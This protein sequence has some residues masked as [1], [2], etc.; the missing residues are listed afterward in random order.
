[1]DFFFLF[2]FFFIE[3]H[4]TA[5][6]RLRRQAGA[7][8]LRVVIFATSPA[9]RAFSIGQ[10]TA[11]FILCGGVRP[12][13]PDRVCVDSMRRALVYVCT[14]YVCTPSSSNA[15]SDNH[16]PPFFPTLLFLAVGSPSRLGLGS[17]SPFSM[18]PL[19]LL[20]SPSWT[21]LHPRD[22][23]NVS[24]VAGGGGQPSLKANH[25]CPSDGPRHWRSTLDPYYF[26]S[27]LLAFHSFPI[28]SP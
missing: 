6:R 21:P 4:L 10:V 7:A 24:N 11:L 15:K 23:S 8:S 13:L 26:T 22:V 3:T 1:M 5:P 16:P 20:V 28:L 19:L 18:F 14:M 2:L 27:I 9:Q 12:F 25:R 17:P